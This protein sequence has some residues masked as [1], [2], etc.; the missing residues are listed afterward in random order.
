[1]AIK[2]IIKVFTIIF[3]FSI[4]LLMAREMGGE[5]EMERGSHPKEG[6]YHHYGNHPN[7]ARR[8]INPA[9]ATRA[10]ERG[11][12]NQS[13]NQANNP[14][15]VVPDGNVQQNQQQMLQNQQQLQQNQQQIEQMLQQ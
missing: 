10:Y 2:S 12:E 7:E 3:G 15:V 11:A 9:E 14:A 4:T 5:H 13:A 6:E 8:N 1:M